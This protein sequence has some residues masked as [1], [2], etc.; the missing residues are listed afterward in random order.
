MNENQRLKRNKYQSKR[1]KLRNKIRIDNAQEE[2]LYEE[3][4]ID[5][6]TLE[7][8]V[9]LPLDRL[10]YSDDTFDAGTTTQ[11]QGWISYLTF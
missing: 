6:D 8:Q 9:K 4:R 1:R 7:G 10:T 5:P 2:I 11:E 3:A